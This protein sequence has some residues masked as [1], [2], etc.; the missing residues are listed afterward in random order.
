MKYDSTGAEGNT[1][2]KQKVLC[3]ILSIVD[4]VVP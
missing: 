1:K 2:S 4:C 3:G